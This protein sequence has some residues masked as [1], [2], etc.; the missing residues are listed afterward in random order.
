MIKRKHGWKETVDFIRSRNVL[1]EA[2]Q[3]GEQ[4]DLL[5]LPV[6]VFV[7]TQ[8]T[9]AEWAGL[10]RVHSSAQRAHVDGSVLI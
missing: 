9:R 10:P 2:Q 5:P 3:A 6:W 4:L 8:V 7:D 1:R